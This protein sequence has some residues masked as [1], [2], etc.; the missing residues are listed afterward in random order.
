[1]NAKIIQLRELISRHAPAPRPQ[2]SG[3]TATGV[4]CFDRALDGGLGK[5]A[6]VELMAD[7]ASSGVSTLL[8]SVLSAAAHAG[9]WSALIDGGDTFN[10]KQACKAALARLLWMRCRSAN[11][12]LRCADF[13]VRDGNLSLVCLDLRANADAEV[14]RIASTAWYRLQR[15]IEP[16]AAALLVLT[17]RPLVP[18]ADVRLEM[19]TPL[20]LET[21]DAGPAEWLEHAELRIARRRSAARFDANQLAEAG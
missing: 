8:C 7:R 6:I 10:P 17:P 4:V 18:C 1:M 12:A 16:T 15:A 5:G 9:R 14:R 3:R 21:L 19:A 13:L 20:S 11:E 2:P